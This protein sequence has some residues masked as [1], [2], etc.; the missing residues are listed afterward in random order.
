MWNSFLLRLTPVLLALGLNRPLLAATQSV[1]CVWNEAALE[2]IKIDF[3]HP[4]VHARNLFHLSTAMY[5]AWAAYDPIAVGYLMNETATSTNLVAAMQEAVSY[6]AYTVLTSRYALSLSATQSLMELETVM[7]NLHYDPT[8]TTTLGTSPAAVGN[9]AAAAALSFAIDDGSLETNNYEDS[10]YVPVNSP[11]IVAFAGTI[12]LDP[13]RWQPLAFDFAETQNGFEAELIQ[14]FLGSQ[15]NQVRPFALKRDDPNGIYLDPGPP[16]FYQGAERNAFR[17][18]NVEVLAFS[19]LLDPDAN[20]MIDISPGGPGKNNPLGQHNGT[21]HPTNP[22]TGLAYASNVVNHADYGRVVAEI[23]ADGPDSE[24]P[25]GHWNA[26]ANEVANHPA[27]T[28][29]FEGSGPALS[30]LEW[31]VKLY[32]ALNAALHDAATAAWTAKVAYDYLRPIS[33]IRHL[34]AKG[35]ASDPLGPNYSTNGIFLVGNLVEVVTLASSAPGQRHE[36]LSAN[37]NAIAINTWP[38][39]PATNTTYSGKEWILAS[40]WMPYQR[41]TFVTPAFAGYVSGHSTFSRAAAEVLTLMTGSPYFPGGLGSYTAA[42]NSL[43]FELG[44]TTNITLQWATYYDAADEAG[45]SRLYGGIHVAPDDFKGR[46]MGSQAG[47]DAYALARKYFDGSILDEPF[48]LD[49]AQA[50]NIVEVSWDQKIGMEYQLLEYNA[51]EGVATTGAYKQAKASQAT[52]L[53]T[54]LTS[55]K[56]FQV[57]QRHE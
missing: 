47:I 8:I 13:N 5:D 48:T 51:L 29:Q 7:T 45:I 33:S 9:R 28:R 44:P 40:T 2:A 52:Q 21:G 18:N 38:G 11:L 10:S 15:W 35:Q 22:V 31:D 55:R 26:I 20:E 19:A 42:Q 24:T 14:T 12:L 39:E 23:W 27:F 43:L 3:P 1:A 36:H 41:N 49:I 54:N 56:Y 57:R 46:I 30:A 16:P 37:L 6:A 34:A 25:P 4:P 32:F 50:T 53:Y 17:S